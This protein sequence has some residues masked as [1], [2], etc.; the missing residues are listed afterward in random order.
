MATKSV[1]ISPH[2]HQTLKVQAAELG[3]PL[4]EYLELMLT[5]VLSQ[6]PVMKHLREEYLQHELSPH[7]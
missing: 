4:Q 2:H 3:I 6:K 5:L 1:K 7:D